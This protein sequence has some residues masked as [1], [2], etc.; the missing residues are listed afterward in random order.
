MTLR[1]RSLE[2]TYQERRDGYFSKMRTK[3]QLQWFKE[4]MG[5]SK[6]EEGKNMENIF[7]KFCCKGK[8]KMKQSQKGI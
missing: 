7:K 8:R 5:G 6:L 2:T 1:S 3:A 4:Q